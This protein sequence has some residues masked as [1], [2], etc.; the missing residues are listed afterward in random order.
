MLIPLT[1][2]T[3]AI[4]ELRAAFMAGK[5]R[6]ILCMLMGAG[7]TLCALELMRLS[8]EKSRKCLFLCDRRMLAQQAIERAE[9]QRLFAGL[10]LSGR[11]SDLSAPCQFASKQT[12]ISWLARG[13]IELPDFELL[14]VD[15]CHRATGEAW[16]APLKLWPNAFIGGLTATP[17]L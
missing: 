14:L 6:G 7:K 4:D 15:A 3:K 2:Q 17:S 5:R 11:G 10:L 8:M 12:V 9:D 13:R 1:Y 16:Q